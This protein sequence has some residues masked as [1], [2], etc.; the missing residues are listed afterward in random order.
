M[1][2]ELSDIWARLR[3]HWHAVAVAVIAALPVILTQLE[4]VDL[5]PL[6]SHIIPAEY[7]PIVVSLLPFVLAI[8]RPMIHMEEPKD[9]A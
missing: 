2:N 5:T 6:L 8:M 4:G 9:D 7:V 3:V 1:L